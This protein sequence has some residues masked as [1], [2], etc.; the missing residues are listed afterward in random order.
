VNEGGGVKDGG[1]PGTC[2][3]AAGG[4]GGGGIGVPA[5]SGRPQGE[6]ASTGGDGGGT[7]APLGLLAGLVV[8]SFAGWLSPKS[9][10]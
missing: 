8:A 7:A 5:I 9:V 2:G 10:T 1:T 3:A 4:G 6:G